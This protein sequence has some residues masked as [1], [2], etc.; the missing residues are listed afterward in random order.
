MVALGTVLDEGET[1][2]SPR[3]I[4][5]AGPGAALLFHAGYEQAVLAGL[6]QVPGAQDWRREIERIPVEE[7]HLHTHVGHMS[8]LNDTDRKVLDGSRIQQLTFSGPEGDLRKR[9]NDV[10]NA[11]VTELV[12]QPA[13]P[14]VEREL[15]AFARMAGIGAT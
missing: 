4:E 14:D 9:I 3:V 10:A 5:A 6:D 11:G 13:G 12:Y 7:R 8:Y 1:Y 15:V 2:D